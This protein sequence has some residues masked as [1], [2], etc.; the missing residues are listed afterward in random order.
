MRLPS[1][2]RSGLRARRVVGFLSCAALLALAAIACSSSAPRP[3]SVRPDLPEV[4]PALRGTLGTE[5]EFRNVAPYLVGGYGLV[6]GLNGT[7]GLPLNDQLS[8]S[9]E[10]Q[11]GLMGV[12]RYSEGL[13]GTALE[14]KTPRQV[15]RDTGIA[16]VTVRAAIAPGAPVGLE[17]DVIVDAVNATSLEGGRLWTCDLRLGP[18]TMFGQTQTRQIGV[19]HGPIYLNPF[20]E[21]SDDTHSTQGRVLG[22]GLVTESLNVVL[23]LYSPSHARARSMVSAINSRFPPEAGD[24]GPIARGRSS[25]SIELYI[26][27]RYRTDALDFLQLVRHLQID[28]RAPE[29]YAR[30]H[31][32]AIKAEPAL[33]SRLSWAL[34]ALGTRALPVIREL[35]D[36]DELIPRLAGLKAGARLNDARAATYLRDLARTGRGTTRTDAIALL[37]QVDAGPGVDQCLR[38]LL[39]E[40]DLI[41]R[42]AA[43]ESLAKRAERARYL[44]LTRIQENN[45]DLRYQKLSPAR[46][47]SIARENLPADSLQGVERHPMEGKFLLDRVHGGVPMVYVT[48]QGVPRI[49]LFGKDDTITLKKVV[50]LWSDRLV[51]TQDAPGHLKARF[52]REGR[53]GAVVESR[54]SLADL[55]EV[56]ARDSTP[57]DPRPGLGL[58]YSEVVAVL[59]A[60]Q[61]SGGTSAAF[62]TERDRLQGQVLA[63]ENSRDMLERPESP[64]DTKPP[65]IRRG[66][67]TVT[68]SQP[69]EPDRPTV[70]PIPG[71]K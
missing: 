59:S 5:V 57:A 3:V 30:R 35:Y 71:G 39:N 60:L 55:I 70:V 27:S 56:L 20:A 40:D 43:Y 32:E 9:M 19:A 52:Q 31:V 10:R 44:Y 36:Y 66:Q 25:Q 23:G 41:V 45:T 65:L 53:P 4:P 6:V 46:L 69:E 13:R 62:A 63:A 26:P 22:G 54:A 7:G 34:E 50:S 12:G 67:E 1:C 18:P 16:V 8:A 2:A 33:A 68:S 29:Q 51:I 64:T 47:E 61:Q 21:D 11:L 48:Q 49:V 37:G 17:F 14:N 24:P 42:I 58:S 28:Q 38:D 15:L